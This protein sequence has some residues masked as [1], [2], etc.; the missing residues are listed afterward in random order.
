MLVAGGV[1]IN[2][3]GV[4]KFSQ[5]SSTYTLVLSQALNEKESFLAWYKK[6]LYYIIR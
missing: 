3:L 6:N 2:Y 5:V 1:H 4:V